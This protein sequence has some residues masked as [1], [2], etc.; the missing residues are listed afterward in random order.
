[1]FIALPVA[2]HAQDSG[3]V[4]GRVLDVAGNGV[5]GVAVSIVDK[6]LSA[7]S[8]D[9]GVYRIAPVPTGTQTLLF[10]F[11]GFGAQTYE[12]EVTWKNVGGMPSALRQARLVKV[13]REDRAMLQFDRDLMTGDEPTVQMAGG[14][15]IDS[16]WTDPGETA[17]ATFEVQVRGS[18]EVEG[19]VR[20]LST[21]GGVLE[22][23]FRVGG[24]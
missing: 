2:L 8:G 23:S 18:A 1:M 10:V 3:V 15:S 14:S 4:T 5:R 9:R 11:M 16:G 22:Q 24:N 21:R 12:V 7:V 13:V 19:T 6:N 20:I 17:S